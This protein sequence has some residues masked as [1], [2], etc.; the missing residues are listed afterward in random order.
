MFYIVGLGNPGEE[1]SETRHN[2][3]F[4]VVQHFVERTG[5]PSL[6]ASA[7]YSGLYSD[8]VFNQAD[9][10]VL[11]P[12]TFM[13]DS[14]SAVQ[15][16]VPKNESK[17]LL[18]VY[19]D[20]DMPLGKIKISFNRGDG[21]HNG[22]KSIIEKLGTREFLRIRIGIA[23]KSMWTGKVLRPTGERL[24]SFVLGRFSNHQKKELEAVHASFE[25]IVSLYIEKGKEVV[26]NTYN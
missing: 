20:V 15:K 24:V 1:Y 22:I 9:I 18:V 12:S 13:N 14:G 23:Q 26:M 21:G 11:L 17:N 7:K 5:L 19:D 6:H 25:N 2:I 3:G 10:S 16:L 4:S 8:G